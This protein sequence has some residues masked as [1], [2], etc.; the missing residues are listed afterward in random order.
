MVH[1]R[2]GLGR[3]GL[4]TAMLLVMM[5]QDPIRVIGRVRAV[6]PGAIET[7]EQEAY[8]LGQRAEDV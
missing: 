5:G 4:V 6:R 1:R 2:A 3:A 7:R 8:V